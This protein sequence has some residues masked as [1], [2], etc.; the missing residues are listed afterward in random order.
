MK[1]KPEKIADKRLRNEVERHLEFDPDLTSTGIGVGADDGVVTLSGYVDTYVEKIAAEQAAHKV[2]GVKA[3]A[4]DLVIRP[5][6]KITDTEIAS[7]AVAALH[8]TGNVPRSIEVTVKGGRVYLEGTAL[9][10]DQSKAAEHACHGLAGVTAIYNRVTVEH[11]DN[12]M[13]Q[14]D[15]R[16]STN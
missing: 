7:S 14:E 13:A 9:S 11:S 10:M 6:Y 3:V 1:P 15:S 16:E 2:G 12:R 8:I 5:L 4:N